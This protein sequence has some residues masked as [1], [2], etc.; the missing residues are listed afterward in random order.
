MTKIV[1]SG[2]EVG[3][4]RTLLEGMKV[5]SM[6]LNFWGLRKRGLPKTKAWLISEHFDPD[7]K[8]Y[9]ESGAKQADEAG[10]SRMELESLAA[11]YQEFVVNNSERA[12]GFQEFDSQVLG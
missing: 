8:V 5:E 1:F 7:T 3:S 9:I 12:E 11:D 6:G 2:T 10:L 4:N